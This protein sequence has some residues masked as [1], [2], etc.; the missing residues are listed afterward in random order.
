MTRGK[1]G[2]GEGGWTRKQCGNVTSGLGNRHVIWGQRGEEEEEM[3]KMKCEEEGE[4]EDGEG[5]GGG[6]GREEGRRRN[7][8]ETCRNV[9]SGFGQQARGM[10]SAW[11]E[12]RRE[13]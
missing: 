1:G 4:E 8:P 13:E 3:N 5:G 6:R 12:R 9:T 11:R 10:G 7:V 2:G